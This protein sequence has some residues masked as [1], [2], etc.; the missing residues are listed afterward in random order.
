M[1]FSK[2]H[3]DPLE[4]ALELLQANYNECFRLL[5]QHQEQLIHSATRMEKLEQLCQQLRLD[6]SDSEDAIAEQHDQIQRLK[7]D[8]SRAAL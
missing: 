8:S 4:I 7:N 6:L 1:S 2:Q 3:K 5:K